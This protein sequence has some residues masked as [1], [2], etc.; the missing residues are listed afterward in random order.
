MEKCGSSSLNV[1]FRNH[2][3]ATSVCAL[4][5]V[6]RS[7]A[8]PSRC[9]SSTILNSTTGSMLGRPSSLLYNGSTISYSLSKT[10]A[11]ST[12]RS[13]CS[14]GTRLSVSTISI[15]PRSSFP[16]SSISPHPFQPI[17]PFLREKVCLLANFFDRLT[18]KAIWLLVF[19]FLFDGLSENPTK[20]RHRILD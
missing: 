15:T 10:T 6:P 2:R 14:G 8:F 12:F 11:A 7:D 13:R 5:S 9:W 1:Y 3:Y 4:R 16:L 17:L 18:R 20:K 19:L